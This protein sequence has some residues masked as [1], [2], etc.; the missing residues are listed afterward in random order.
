M[1]TFGNISGAYVEQIEFDSFA[2]YEK[3]QTKLLKDKEFSKTEQEAM[4][5][6]DTSTFS[7]SALKPVK[8]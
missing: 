1:Q 6:I 3:C 5:L 2:E 4:I 7:M 8:Y